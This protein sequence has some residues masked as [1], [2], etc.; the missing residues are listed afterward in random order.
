MV[1]TT[2]GLQSGS[3]SNVLIGFADSETKEEKKKKKKSQHDQK[4]ET[5]PSSK[6]P[7]EMGKFPL[8]QINWWNQ[9]KILLLFVLVGWPRRRKKTVLASEFTRGALVTRFARTATKVT[10]N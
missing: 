10:S 2:S 5:G 1:G 4:E 7:G 8:D 6:T 9:K 3:K